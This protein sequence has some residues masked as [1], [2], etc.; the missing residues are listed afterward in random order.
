MW[1]Y[2]LRTNIKSSPVQCH[3]SD[4]YLLCDVFFKSRTRKYSNWTSSSFLLVA[5]L[6]LLH[7]SISSIRLY[8]RIFT[9]KNPARFLAVSDIAKSHPR[10]SS[11][12]VK[13][14]SAR[15]HMWNELLWTN[16]FA[17][18]S[19][20]YNSCKSISLKS[21]FFSTRF[22]RTLREKYVSG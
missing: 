6:L 18:P 8:P 17:S 16:E 12:T 14:G 4:C 2:H 11:W 20:L 3:G 10:H 1:I 15:L 22:V 9:H 13:S 7:W 21:I 5:A 19:L